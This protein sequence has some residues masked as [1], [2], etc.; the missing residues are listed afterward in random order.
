MMDNVQ[1]VSIVLNAL[2]GGGLLLTLLTFRSYKAKTQGEAAQA[3]AQAEVVEA[4]ATSAEI[5]NIERIAKMWREQAEMFEQKWKTNDEQMMLLSETVN[6]LKGEV[7]R[8]VGINTKIVKALDKINADNYE[9]IIEQIKA[10]VH[11]D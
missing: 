5:D 7:K 2:L 3:T 1:I 9:R 10:D 11:A 6:E 8:L 4:Q